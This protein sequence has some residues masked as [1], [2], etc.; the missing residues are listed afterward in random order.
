MKK[1]PIAFIFD[2]D[3]TIIG[4]SRSY[5]E[6]EK[7]CKL[8]KNACKANAIDEKLCNVKLAPWESFITPEFSAHI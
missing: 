1:K 4:Y 3:N 6:Y 2:L 8:F 7:F 5:L